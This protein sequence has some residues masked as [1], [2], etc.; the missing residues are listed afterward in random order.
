MTYSV[1]RIGQTVSHYRIVNKLGGGGMGV[2]YKAEDTRL[3]RF[4]ALKFLS[5]ESANDPDSMERLRREAEAASALNHPNICTIYDIGGDKGLA[6]IAME[7]LDGQMLK[8]RIAGRPLPLA[9]VLDLGTEIA[10]GLEAAHS[11]GIVHRDIKSANIFVTKRCHAKIVD[12]GLAKLRP[13][14][15][16]ET[17]LTD[18]TFSGPTELGDLTRPGS[19]MGTVAYMSPEQVRGE[20]LDSRTDIF[21]FGIVLYEMATGQLAFPGATT[22]VI[23]EGILNRAPVPLTRLVSYDGLELE[24]IVAKALQK[25][26]KL[27]YQTMADL[28]A[29]LLLCQNSISA[30]QAIGNVQSKPVALEAP[31]PKKRLWKVG[32]PVVSLAIAVLVAGGLY[33]RARR[34]QKLTEADTIM[35]ADF[36][37]STGD[38]VFDRT[39]R[40]GLAAQLE[41]SPF[42]SLLSDQ[43]IEQTLALMAHPK[44]APLVQDLAREVCQR[45]NSTASIEGSIS[46]L[47]SQ[48]VLGLQALN[49]RT[50]DHLAQE[51]ETANGKEQVLAALGRAATKLREKLGD[52]LASVQKYDVSMDRV[53]TSSLDALRAYSLAVRKYNLEGDAA[54]IPFLKR[55][56]ELD[57]KFASAYWKLAVAHYDIGELEAAREYSTK[58]YLLRASV[59]EKERYVISGWYEQL[60]TGD[61]ESAIKVY[62]VYSKEYPREASAHGDLGYLLAIIGQWARSAEESKEAIRL[63]PSAAIYYGNIVFALRGLNRLDEADTACKQAQDRNLESAWLISDC[64]GLAFVQGDTATM[65]KLVTAAAGQVGAEDL[66][67]SNASDT[68]AY[69]GRRTKAREL[70]RRAVES[71]LRDNRK[72]A[73]ALWQLNSALREGEFGDA[74][75][76]RKQAKASLTLT[77]SRDVQ[78][79][80]ELILARIGEMAPSQDPLGE[81]AKRFPLNTAINRYWVP[82]AQAS[83]ALRHDEVQAVDILRVTDPYELAYPDPTLQTGIF[84]YPVFVRGEA[85]LRARKGREAQREFQKYFEHRAAAVNCPLGA[86]ARLQLGR[87]YLLTSETDKARQ[88]YQEFLGLWKDA[89]PDVP[90]LKQAREE[91][92]K[93]SSPAN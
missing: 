71:A 44:D 7:F 89:D 56:V 45:T 25:D 15:T 66:L 53:T 81:L 24:R 63:D 79:L 73:A 6:F 38:P 2:V 31:G 88:V 74:E 82:T 14:S 52:S 93:L 80:G 54:S 59:S 57:P 30:G 69:Y 4:V 50:G 51:Q 36:A 3:H 78:L 62:E 39:L 77:H 64:Y 28:R 92:A 90:I 29:D 10:D 76:A 35:I 20:N 22:G 1:I 46:N 72:E 33:N 13:K 16:G 70:S 8:D 49:C 9:E 26:R 11:L 55:A 84:L 43:R 61:I 60:A 87:S 34:F 12:F 67:L 75:T 32:I 37:N 19:M 5:A 18:Y 17:T 91:F 21:S 23:M 40:Q 48:Y 86:L 47:G 65:Q 42:L 58:A 85:Y 27:R 41:Q 83:L 68:E